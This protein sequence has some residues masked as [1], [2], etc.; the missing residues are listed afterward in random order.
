MMY[1]QIGSLPYDNVQLAVAYS[2]CHDIPFLPELPL[3][4]DS[5]L[6]YIKQPE[7]L[8]CLSE[9]K[10]HEFTQVK[11]Q[12]VG[13]TTLLASGY[14]ED[15]ALTRIYE[16]VSSIMDGLIADK[17]FLWFYNANAPLQIRHT[18]RNRTR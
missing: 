17:I 9:F 6:T 15:E 13:P 16:H 12:C 8:S 2:L 3:L 14:S 7:K 11:I 18:K 5:M 1:T 10:K 4:G